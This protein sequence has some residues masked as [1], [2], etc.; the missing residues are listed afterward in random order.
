MD[1]QVQKLTAKGQATRARII[2]GAAAEIRERGVALTTI[3]DVMARTHTSKSQIFHYF[4]RGKEQLLV[5]VA[6][7][8]SQRVLDD[9]Q[10]HLSALTSWAAWQRWR[11]VVVDRYR[12]Q[13]QNCPI[14]VLMS[15]IG[16]TST[17]AQ[18]VTT[19]LIESWR[20]AIANGIVAMQQQDKIAH[21]VDAERA[22]AALLAGIQGGVGIMLATGDLT[23]LEAALDEGIGAL[24]QR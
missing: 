17:G 7:L 21:T 24:R 14:A 18:A 20:S 4:P 2:D 11:D 16:R 23:Y 19:E 6:T 10:P 15:E 22:A 1:P 3:E 8:E 12:K 5:A 13:G 9:Q